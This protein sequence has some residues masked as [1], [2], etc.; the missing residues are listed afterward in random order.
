LN[1]A[2][3]VDGEI[4]AQTIVVAVVDAESQAKATVVAALNFRYRLLRAGGAAGMKVIEAE[5]VEVLEV[6]EVIEVDLVE[7][8]E[9]DLVEAI[10][11]AEVIGVDLVVV[12]VVAPWERRSS[13]DCPL[14]VNIQCTQRL[15][16]SFVQS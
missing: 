16:R 8:I 12:V 4:E 1:V 5:L 10:E 15:T 7:V 6:I 11:A 2:A 9:A 14:L 3:V 13:R